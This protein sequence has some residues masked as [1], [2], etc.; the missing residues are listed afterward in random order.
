MSTIQ[1]LN[2]SFR[3]SGFIGGELIITCGVDALPP[4]EKMLLVKK[5]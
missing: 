5:L 4:A 2:D 3:T 1:E